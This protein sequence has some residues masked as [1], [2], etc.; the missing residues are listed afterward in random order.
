MPGISFRVSDNGNYGVS[1]LRG[2][3][4][5]T[6][7]D[8][9]P[10][11]LIPLSDSPMIVLWQQTNLPSVQKKWLAYKH[12]SG[13]GEYFSD[14]IESG[15]NGW[16]TVNGCPA[17]N[18]PVPTD[19]SACTGLWHISTRRS[20]SSS[21]SWYYGREATGNFNTG[22][23]NCGSI[24]SP[25]IN[26]TA[27]TSALLSFWS[28]YETEL[29]DVDTY[30]VKLIDI[31][32]GTSWH[33]AKYQIAS[34]EGTA[35]S[36]QKIQIDLKDYI[37]STIKVRF[38]F[39]TRDS[40][41]NDYEGWY[42]D[43]VMIKAVFP[44]NEATLT[45]R[46][47]EGA[48]LKFTT[49]GTGSTTPI[50]GGDIVIQGTARGTVVGD[51]I[52]ESGS[53]AGGNAV[54]IMILNKVFGTFLGNQN[55]YV[56]GA[57]LAKTQAANFFR[58]RDNYIRAYYSDTVGFGTPS[59]NYLNYDKHGYPRGADTQWPP[60]KTEDWSA[61]NDYFTLVQ[62][63]TVRVQG[64]V[65]VDLEINTLNRIPSIAEPYAIIRSN[66]LTTTTGSFQATTA[67]LGLHTFGTGSYSTN[68]YFDDFALQTQ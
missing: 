65:P 20:Y 68:V 55:L 1:F 53:W 44:V 29:V 21:H 15:T 32:D 58:D 48:S 43:D 12:L 22:A 25:P 28:W 37:G 49:T 13:E 45:V 14:N 31:Y 42:I 64:E 54:G 63:D 24:E 52:I 33:Q 2:N 18:T 27:A 66:A 61:A 57:V 39:D 41:Y 3:K 36:W 59:A 5:P 19:C 16:T 67:E 46:V 8:G 23:R 38:R 7:D 34:L 30:D 35:K 40:L 17:P 50:K 47:I 26:L 60:D 11:D 56:N 4:S 10:N 6:P 9:I 51:P 62:W